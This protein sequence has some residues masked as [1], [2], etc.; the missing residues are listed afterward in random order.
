MDEGR[1]RSRE[2]RVGVRGTVVDLRPAVLRTYTLRPE[3]NP[4][5]VAL[6]EIC[7][8]QLTLGGAWAACGA[9]CKRQKQSKSPDTESSPAP[10]GS[11]A[12]A[13]GHNAIR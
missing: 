9:T 8:W 12:V 13:M 7:H 6:R 4:R 3:P 11:A 5:Q 10:T 1:V 2:K